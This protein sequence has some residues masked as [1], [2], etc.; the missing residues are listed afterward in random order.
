MKVTPTHATTAAREIRKQMKMVGDQL[1]YHSQIPSFLT[2]DQ[3][4]EL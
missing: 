1:S 2:E 3:V 4:K